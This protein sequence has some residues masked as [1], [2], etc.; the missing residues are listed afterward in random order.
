MSRRSLFALTIALAAAVLVSAVPSFASD[1]PLPIAPHVVAP[2]AVFPDDVSLTISRDGESVTV[3]PSRTIVVRYV[4]QPGAV[5]PWH[6][7]AGPV[8]VNVRRGTFTYVSD[9]CEKTTYQAREAFVDLG[10]DVHS[11]FAG[12]EETVVVAT[13]FNAPPWPDPLLIPATAPAGCTIP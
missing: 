2:R 13:F 5:F 4:V 12:P 10:T 3:E 7:H 6:T 1:A 9:A 11:A 8:V